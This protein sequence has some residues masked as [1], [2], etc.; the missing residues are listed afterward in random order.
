MLAVTCY[1]RCCQ[2]LHNIDMDLENLPHINKENLRTLDLNSKCIQLDLK[3][4]GSRL[5]MPKKL[6]RY[7]M[8]LCTGALE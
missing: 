8:Q 7:C 6:L 2:N 1:K 3:T 5:I 4:L